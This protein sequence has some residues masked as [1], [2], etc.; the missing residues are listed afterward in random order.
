VVGF[1]G[2][3]A[4]IRLES[5]AGCGGCGSRGTCGSGGR[6]AQV[7]RMRL[8]GHARLGDRVT[9]SMPSSSVALAGLLGYLLPPGCLLLG[10]IIAAGRYEGDA[11]AVL[12][13]GLGLVAGLLLAR[14]I[15][16]F[17]LGRGAN[18]AVCGPDSH[19]GE[20]P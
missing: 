11:A 3:L 18:P 13:A 1:D 4:R 8:P 17:A 6:A 9:V 7:V 15:A 10:T 16:Y 5:A 14:L 20:H 12:G 2:E 19:P